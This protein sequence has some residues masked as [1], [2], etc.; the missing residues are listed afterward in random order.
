MAGAGA[1]GGAG[2]GCPSAPAFVLEFDAFAPFPDTAGQAAPRTRFARH[3]E[4]LGRQSSEVSHVDAGR[5]AQ[6]ALQAASTVTLRGDIDAALLR[7]TYRLHLRR[8]PD[9]RLPLLLREAIGHKLSGETVVLVLAIGHRCRLLQPVNA[10]ADA[11]ARNWGGSRRTDRR[12]VRGRSAA[13]RE[14]GGAGAAKAAPQPTAPAQR[15][16]PGDVV[17]EVAGD[18]TVGVGLTGLRRIVAGKSEAILEVTLCRSHLP[19]EM[20]A[21]AALKGSES[22]RSAAPPSPASPSSKRHRGSS[23][24]RCEAAPEP[25]AQLTDPEMQGA[26]SPCSPIGGLTPLGSVVAWRSLAASL[27]GAAG[28]GSGNAFDCVLCGASV[29]A[30]LYSQHMLAC[31]VARSTDDGSDA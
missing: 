18:S 2:S 26:R 24:A 4:S 5:E 13:S 31:A 23:V 6:L 1:I 14:P 16:A 29:P 28:A 10:D 17:V 30:K 3:D 12:R 20:E 22:P 11:L 19:R 9:K 21:P 7:D 25:A 27:D 15:V 8:G